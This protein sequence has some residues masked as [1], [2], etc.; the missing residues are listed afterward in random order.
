MNEDSKCPVTG[1]ANKPTAGGGT[2]IRNWWPNQLN[3]NI[4]HQHS[5]NSNPMGEEFNYAEEFKSLDLEALKKDPAS[6]CAFF[7][8]GLAWLLVMTVL[9]QIGPPER[10][11]LLFALL[12]LSGFIVVFI[13]V[14]IC[15]RR[16]SGRHIVWVILVIGILGRL[17]FLSSPVS[18]IL[19]QDIRDRYK[20]TKGLN[21][22]HQAL[23]SLDLGGPV[24]GETGMVRDGISH[25]HFTA[26]YPPFATLL[27]RGWAAVSRAEWT[28][29]IG[30]FVFDFFSLIMLVL[31]VKQKGLS[32]SRLMFYALNPLTLLFVAGEGHVPVI[33]TASL[34]TGL[35]L[36][37]AGRPVS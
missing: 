24:H 1:G 17:V 35:Y 18:E 31:L 21:P 28:L 25:P 9:S 8:L 37:G 23:Y 3:L 27:F 10:T 36:L 2:S 19:Q 16:W 12:Y 7:L 14:R 4:L 26:H 11:P 34:F 6:T 32:P 5:S 22:D 30:L 33:L 20:E 13:M 29:R 15:P